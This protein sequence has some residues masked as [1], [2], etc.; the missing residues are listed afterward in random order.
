MSY[1]HEV[2]H[3]AKKLERPLS[4]EHD[5]KSFK[6]K[7][8]ILNV[9]S[10]EKHL[11]REVFGLGFTIEDAAYDFIRKAKGLELE[12]WLTDKIVDVP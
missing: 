4:I 3:L 5:T 12:N 10:K 6:Y 11:W 7:V 1:V 9:V 8:F 2:C